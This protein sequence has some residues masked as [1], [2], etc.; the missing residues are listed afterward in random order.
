MEKI[1]K[2][3]KKHKLESTNLDWVAYDEDTKKLYVCFKQGGSIYSYDDVPADIFEGL[4]N[5][6]SH[7]RYF[8]VKIKW[9]YKYQKLT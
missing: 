2:D 8:A 9:K 7:G 6:G 1:S 3:L 4:L 5:A